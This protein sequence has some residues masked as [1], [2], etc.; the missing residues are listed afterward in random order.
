[1][2]KIPLYSTEEI[3]IQLNSWSSSTTDEI[4]C[5]NV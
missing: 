2:K 4:L 5:R 1:L 3:G